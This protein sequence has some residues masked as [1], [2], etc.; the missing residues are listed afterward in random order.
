MLRN[1]TSFTLLPISPSPNH[2]IS[3][4]LWISISSI[5]Q[6]WGCREGEYARV[7]SLKLASSPGWKGEPG[8]QYR[9]VEDIAT[10]GSSSGDGVG[11]TWASEIYADV[12]W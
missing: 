3:S 11:D 1:L 4:I 2:T 10:G 9:L 8:V 5:I 12:S 6:G 7:G